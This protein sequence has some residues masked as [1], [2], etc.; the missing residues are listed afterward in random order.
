ME[1]KSL[2]DINWRRPT[3]DDL[4]SLYIAYMDLL[5]IAVIHYRNIDEIASPYV[6]DDARSVICAS[7][8]LT[9]ERYDRYI[10]RA[11]KILAKDG[12]PEVFITDIANSSNHDLSDLCEDL[13][14]LYDRFMDE[15]Y[16]LQTEFNAIVARQKGTK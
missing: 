16:E 7:T 2:A 9:I 1:D 11:S 15:Q 14:D 12:A 5:T 10:E 8:G 13:E 6:V 4:R 3:N